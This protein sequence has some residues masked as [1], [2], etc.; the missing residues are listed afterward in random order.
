MAYWEE[1]IK[2]IRRGIARLV[3]ITM[4]AMVGSAAFG[5]IDALATRIYQENG[6]PE[7]TSSSTDPETILTSTFRTRKGG[8]VAIFYSAECAVFAD[9]TNERVAVNIV[10]DDLVLP[11][12]ANRNLCSSNGTDTNTGY[13]SNAINAT[14]NLGPGRHTVEIVAE[15]ISLDGGDEYWIADQSL[16]IIVQKR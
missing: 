15:G 16:T 4:M 2:M 6:I 13:S 14:V 11:V 5:S 7:V 12:T 3:V 1:I 10:V 9:G 8:P